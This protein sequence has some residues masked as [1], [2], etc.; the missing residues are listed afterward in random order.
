MGIPQMKH[1]SAER[2]KA[3]YDPGEL[4]V[5][6]GLAGPVY[7][8]KGDAEELRARWLRAMLWSLVVPILVMAG[9]I[10]AG[11]YSTAQTEPFGALADPW[12]VLGMFGFAWIFQSAAGFVWTRLHADRVDRVPWTSVD[13]DT[14]LDAQFG[15]MPAARVRSHVNVLSFWTVVGLFSLFAMALLG[16]IPFLM[17]F[18]VAIMLFTT[19]TS[20]RVYQLRGQR[21]PRVGEEA[22]TGT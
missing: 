11:T 22:G 7:R 19:L 13:L 8:I 10:I 12:V 4:L 20:F 18:V 17:G 15:L 6:S 2:T 5:P 14:R 21:E 3:D 16:D 9:V 1:F